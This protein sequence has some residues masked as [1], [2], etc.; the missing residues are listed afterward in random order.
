MISYSL[1][2]TSC[3][4]AVMPTGNDFIPSL[5]GSSG[6]SAGWGNQGSDI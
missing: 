3:E 1:C 4:P 6:C 2:H 5:D